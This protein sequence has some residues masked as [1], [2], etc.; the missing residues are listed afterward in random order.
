MTKQDENTQKILNKFG[1]FHVKSK[2]ILFK[3]KLTTLI[4][5]S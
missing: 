1:N 4:T 2:E 3:L 5:T